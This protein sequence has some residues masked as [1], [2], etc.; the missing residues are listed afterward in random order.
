ML[1]RAIVT[2]PLLATVL[3]LALAAPD[4]RAQSNLVFADNFQPVQ[5][6]GWNG[7]SWDFGAATG[8]VPTTQFPSGNYS[9]LLYAYGGGASGWAVYN[10]PI[11]AGLSEWSYQAKAKYDQSLLNGTPQPGYYGSGGLLIS[12]TGDMSGDFIWVGLDCNLGEFDP[13]AGVSWARPILEYRLGGETGSRVLVPPEVDSW[14]AVR[15]SKGKA[16]GPAT[17]TASRTAGSPGT[18]T[19]VVDSPVDGQRVATINFTGAAATALDSLKYVGFVNYF[20]QWEYDDVSVSGG[21]GEIYANDF[22]NGGQP[23]WNTLGNAFWWVRGAT[24]GTNGLF[25]F[26]DQAVADG[27]AFYTAP[28]LTNTSVKWSYSGQAK[29]TDSTGVNPWYGVGGLVL[30]S[31]QNGSDYLWVGYSRYDYGDTNSPGS[32]WCY[33]FY[34]YRLGGTTGS[35]NFTGPFRDFPDSPPVGITVSRAPGANELTLVVETPL[36]G[37]QTNTITVATN[38]AAVLDSLQYVGL[39]NYFGAFQYDN[40][41]VMGVSATPPT[42]GITVSNSV[43]RVF[44]P[45][46]SDPGFVLESTSDLA[47]PTWGSAGTP[48]VE[49]GNNVVTN[50][51]TGSALFYRLKK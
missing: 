44:W 8:V 16:L 17:L 36:D 13:A 47:S 39:R 34:D 38:A 25:T 9:Y 33:A 23:G 10:T 50:S 19:F 28:V 7:M 21:S 3:A 45:S 30:A 6:E 4:L 35:G 32:A 5:A 15:M 26:R 37:V 41:V 12:A 27:Y 40:L 2:C 29:W 24:G 48:F 22:E 11:L 42:L 46:T 31:D 18:I 1:A 51:L 43:A 49:G 14:G 20:S